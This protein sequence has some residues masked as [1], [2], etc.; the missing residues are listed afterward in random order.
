MTRDQFID[1]VDAGGDI[2]LDCRGKHFTICNWNDRPIDIAEQ[3]TGEN[4]SLYDTAEDLADQYLID[5][6]PIGKMLDQVR[7]TFRS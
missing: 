6:I 5:G 7:I 3:S 4:H 1:T 2:M